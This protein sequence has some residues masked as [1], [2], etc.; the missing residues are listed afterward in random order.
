LNN[1]QLET[2]TNFDFRVSILGYYFYYYL[3]LLFCFYIYFLLSC[4]CGTG[5]SSTRDGRFL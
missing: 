4:I 5:V 3:S 1:K 2:M